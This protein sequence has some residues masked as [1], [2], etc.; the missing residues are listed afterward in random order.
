MPLPVQ[1]TD[2]E[3]ISALPPLPKILFNKFENTGDM[4]GTTEE[5][6]AHEGTR[7]HSLRT[8]DFIDKKLAIQKG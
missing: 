6:L 7:P 4:F 3:K 8:T 5:F 1:K 2:M